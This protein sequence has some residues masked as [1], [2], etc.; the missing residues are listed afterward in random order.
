MIRPSP[1]LVFKWG[2]V[3][4][5][6]NAIYSGGR[7]IRGRSPR[8]G[9]HCQ[10]YNHCHYC[11]PTM[12]IFAN[13]ANQTLPPLPIFPTLQKIAIITNQPLLLLPSL[14]TNHCHHCHHHIYQCSTQSRAETLG[15]DEGVRSTGRRKLPSLPSS[16]RH[17][18]DYD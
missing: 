4:N 9:K 8:H 1:F 15:K 5:K 18:D 11:Q 17:D 7:R 2:G 16:S 6:S 3:F 13:I 12:A 10:H 14:P